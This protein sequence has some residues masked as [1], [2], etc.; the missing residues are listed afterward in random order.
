MPKFVKFGVS[1]VLA[2]FCFIYITLF[3][4]I[5]SVIGLHCFILQVL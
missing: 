2:A 5:E 1:V 4:Y 3:F